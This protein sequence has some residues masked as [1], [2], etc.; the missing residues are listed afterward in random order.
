MACWHLIHL[1]SC[2][3]YLVCSANRNMGEMKKG[4][5]KEKIVQNWMMADKKEGKKERKI[6]RNWKM[7]RKKERKKE[8]LWETER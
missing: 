3:Q 1:P 6:V 8:R 7:A 4:M 2:H 5:N